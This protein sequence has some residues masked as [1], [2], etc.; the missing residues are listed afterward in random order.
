V[1]LNVL[2]LDV[3][4]AAQAADDVITWCTLKLNPSR[5]SGAPG[6]VESADAE[7]RILWQQ[8]E[9]LVVMDGI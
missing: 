3:L 8:A 7:A 4:R 2:Q 5:D 1:D 9:T 6:T